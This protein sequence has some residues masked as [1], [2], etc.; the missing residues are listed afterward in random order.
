V[1]VGADQRPAQHPGQRFVLIVGQPPEE[2]GV[3]DTERDAVRQF[4]IELLVSP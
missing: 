4:S 3:G 1:A 2:Y